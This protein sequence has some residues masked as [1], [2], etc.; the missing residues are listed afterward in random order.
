MGEQQ[1]LNEPENPNKRFTSVDD[2]LAQFDRTVV[3]DYSSSGTG[4]YQTC[5][6]KV[7]VDCV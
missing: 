4:K 2:I 5:I 6:L 7:V 3:S 1:D